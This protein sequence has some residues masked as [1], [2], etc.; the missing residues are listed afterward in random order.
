MV[1]ALP[2][3][4]IVLE[5]DAPYLSPTQGERNEPRNVK[6]SA[7]KIAELKRVGVSIVEDATTENA[8]RFFRLK[9]G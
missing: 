7:E 2:L 3:E 5:T 9:N 4:S 6:V 1:E 8:F